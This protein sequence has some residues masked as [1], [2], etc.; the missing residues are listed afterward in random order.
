MTSATVTVSA[1]TRSQY[2]PSAPRLASTRPCRRSSAR[3]FSRNLIGMSCAVAIRSPLTGPSSA[4]A[5]S[6]SARSA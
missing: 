3:M 5:N 1:G 2:P 4:D 6:I